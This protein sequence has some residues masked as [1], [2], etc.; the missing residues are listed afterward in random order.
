MATPVSGSPVSSSA[1]STSAGAGAVGYG[2]AADPVSAAA[3]S[4]LHSGSDSD[5]SSVELMSPA[6]AAADMKA[7]AAGGLGATLGLG[8]GA[9]AGGVSLRPAAG[10]RAVTLTP[11]SAT[12][13]DLINKKLEP[14]SFFR[15]LW[16]KHKLKLF[17]VALLVITVA[18]AMLCPF[19]APLLPA[20]LMAMKL[21]G[22]IA[23]CTL[24]AYLITKM[25]VPDTDAIKEKGMHDRLSKDR[26]GYLNQ[27]DREI[28]SR[29]QKP[30]PGAS[31]LNQAE[32]DEAL[33][34]LATNPDVYD[35]L[36]PDNDDSKRMQELLTAKAKAKSNEKQHYQDQI[37]NLELKRQSQLNDILRDCVDSKGHSLADMYDL[38]SK[39]ASKKAPG[40][41]GSAGGAAAAP[42]APG[43]VSLTPVDDE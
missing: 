40:G 4:R 18:V 7:A 1:S 16:E 33:A 31:T 9:G 38:V 20:I 21:G 26:K 10:K 43:A 2:A 35:Y 11:M 28:V 3:L 19:A 36:N 32:K 27:I 42:G 13:N 29:L 8:S 17:I 14:K 5:G 37:D 25:T 24:P 23:L 30:G 12:V 39:K 34:A 22:V 41:A 15:N 6:A